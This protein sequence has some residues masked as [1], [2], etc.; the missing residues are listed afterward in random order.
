MR[1]RNNE[2]SSSREVYTAQQVEDV[3]KH[4]GVEVLEE[5]DN[6]I[7]SLCPY[8]GNSDTPAFSTSKRYG[9]SLCFN[10]ACGVG[11]QGDR[12]TLERLVREVGGLDHVA[13][14][15]LI[16]L[17]GRNSTF[18]ERFDSIEKEPE[19][20]QEFS[21]VAIQKMRDRFWATPEAKSYMKGRGFQKETM[22]YF[23][24]GFALASTGYGVSVYRAHDMV[25]VPA[26]DVKNR[27]VGLVG[28]TIVGKEFKNY[29]PGKGGKGFH[30]SQTMWNIQNAKKHDVVIVVESTFDA[31]RVHQAG[32]PNVVA[33]LGGSLSEIQIQMFKRYFKTVIIM[34]DNEGPDDMV[35]HR[36][37]RKCLGVGND[38]CQGHK[39]GRD[40]G[41]KISES[42]P[43]VSIKWAAFDN[44]TV[45]A[46]GAKDASDMTDEQIR[47]CL[48]NAVSHF[49]YL[50]WVA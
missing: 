2:W 29:G 26:Y 28:R 1:S 46:P 10:P 12:L 48:R 19:E 32:Y 7:L 9:Y 24:I 38:M 34:T 40:L 35:F 42:L 15:R 21:S 22:E 43:G 11:S 3:L 41:M 18:A 44:K 13:A 5:T 31:M 30:K 14:K 4:I 20:M 47:Q 49:E 27:P 16:F 6:D 50:D 8:H 36:H 23:N 37:C 45:Y 17:R 33:L 25:M 39:P